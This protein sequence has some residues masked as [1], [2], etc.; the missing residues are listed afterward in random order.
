M[1]WASASS[2]LLCRKSGKKASIL[3]RLQILVIFMRSILTIIL[4]LMPQ[5][6][7]ASDMAGLVIVVL[8]W[9]LAIVGL[10]SILIR[11]LWKKTFLLVINILIALFSL[12]FAVRTYQSSY[13]HDYIAHWFL[14]P[15]L[16]SGVFVYL[17]L[18]QSNNTASKGDTKDNSAF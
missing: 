3:L 8:A 7:N 13:E 6:A 14:L 2:Y 11:P 5:L 10:L 1:F 18:K 12:Y 16:L 9:P 17:H 15:P 4:I